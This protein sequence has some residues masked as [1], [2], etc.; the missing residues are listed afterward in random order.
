VRGKWLAVVGM[1]LFLNVGTSC[2][3]ASQQDKLVREDI[4]DA[5]QGIVLTIAVQS[6]PTEREQNCTCCVGPDPF[7]LALAVIGDGTSPDSLLALAQ[8]VRFAL[9]GMYSEEYD[10]YVMAKG[11]RIRKVFRSLNPEQLHEQCLHEFAN[12]QKDKSY[13]KAIQGARENGVC[14]SAGAIKEHIQEFVSA[15]SRPPSHER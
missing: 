6:A 9:D 4:K 8:L 2:A 15:L 11:K 12:L 5:E 3:T 13:A 1:V 14:E 7:F 10:T